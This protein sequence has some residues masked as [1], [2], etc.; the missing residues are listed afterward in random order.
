MSLII[1]IKMVIYLHH[2]LAINKIIPFSY[3]SGSYMLL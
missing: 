3:H 2:D 1:N